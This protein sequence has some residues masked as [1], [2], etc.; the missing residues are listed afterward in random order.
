MK[1]VEPSLPC[2]FCRKNTGPPSFSRISQATA[3][4]SGDSTSS[5]DVASTKSSN[6]LPIVP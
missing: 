1:N 3:R 2:R 5:A 4:N 6:R